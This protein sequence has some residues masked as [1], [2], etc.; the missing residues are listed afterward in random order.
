MGAGLSGELDDLYFSNGGIGD[1]PTAELEFGGAGT[2]NPNEGTLTLDS[3][4]YGSFYVSAL[5]LAAGSVNAQLPVPFYVEVFGSTE[6]RVYG[7]ALPKVEVAELKGV[8][9]ALLYGTD[10]LAGVPLD[11]QTLDRRIAAYASDSV[12]LLGNLRALYLECYKFSTGC[13]QVSK[14]N[15]GFAIAGLAIEIVTFGLA[16]PAVKAGAKAAKGALS[17]FRGAAKV[18][19]KEL[20][21]GV[22]VSFA[23]TESIEA[24]GKEVALLAKADPAPE[25]FTSARDVLSALK[26]WLPSLPPGAATEPNPAEAANRLIQ[27]PQDLHALIGVAQF[28]ANDEDDPDVGVDT[29][30]SAFVKE[31]L[32][33]GRAWHTER[34]DFGLDDELVWFDPGSS[35]NVLFGML[36]PLPPFKEIAGIAKKPIAEIVSVLKNYADEIG[37][38][39]SDK[40]RLGL[41]R[42]AKY[43]EVAGAAASGR[44]VSQVSDLYKALD[45][46]PSSSARTEFLEAFEDSMKH[47]AD[48]A[49][50]TSDADLAKRIRETMT[51]VARGFALH[52][53]KSGR[54]L[55]RHSQGQRYVIQNMKDLLD[56]LVEIEPSALDGAYGSLNKLYRD[57]LV[58]AKPSHP[59]SKWFV[60]LKNWSVWR[61][62]SMLNSVDGHLKGLTPASVSDQSHG[63]WIR[64]SCAL[65][66]AEHANPRRVTVK[67]FYEE[68]AKKF[69][70][71][72]DLVRPA[73]YDTWLEYVAG[74]PPIWK[75]LS[76]G[77]SVQNPGKKANVWLESVPD[78][79]V[80]PTPQ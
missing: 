34:F 20:A 44:V 76:G 78:E 70:K 41:E 6:R 24:I 33:R 16:S 27:S 5:P 2:F 18:L 45:L 40:A 14:L 46:L 79:L 10:S 15:V 66:I 13:D 1:S 72:T 7:Y 25:W 3:N 8:Q 80:T 74:K 61:E 48:L 35:S 54:F 55:K 22:V 56:D 31:F 69:A 65:P 47:M 62:R 49:D 29:D 9:M 28:A 68:V 64:V 19:S 50:T 21:I 37:E 38:P 17:K 4:G 57:L 73:G 42:F 51:M 53:S 52:S 59:V 26:D 39:L 32:D 71:R 43:S 60:E 67:R 23:L 11:Q 58:N 75:D 36:L 77:V 63:L 30:R 12:P